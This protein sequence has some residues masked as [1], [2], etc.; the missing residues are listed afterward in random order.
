MSGKTQINKQRNGRRD[1][2]MRKEKQRKDRKLEGSK[3][4]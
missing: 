3:A 4:I 1:N 2:E